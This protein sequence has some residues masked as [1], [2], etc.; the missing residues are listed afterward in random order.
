M[1]L[2]EIFL[3]VASPFGTENLWHI[4]SKIRESD[5]SKN[6]E[7][8]VLKSYTLDILNT[9]I[10]YD[11]ISICFAFENETIKSEE[12]SD[13]VKRIENTW[14]QETDFSDLYTMVWFKFNDWYVDGLKKEGLSEST[15][16]NMFTKKIGN[17]ENWMEKNRPDKIDKASDDN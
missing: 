17:L 16:W 12:Y 15:D 7:F 14:I 4:I 11:M 3:S 8:N 1:S 9:M 13:L 2:N 10:D 5:N 6:I